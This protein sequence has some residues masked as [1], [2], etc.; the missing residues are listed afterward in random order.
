M[1]QR[2][3]Q[4]PAARANRRC[5]SGMASAHERTRDATQCRTGERF[6]RKQLRLHRPTG[7]QSHRQRDGRD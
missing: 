7:A 1:N 5:L 2:A 4:K 3:Q 6:R